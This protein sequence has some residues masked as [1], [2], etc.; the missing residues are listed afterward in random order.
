MGNRVAGIVYVKVD[1][2]QLRTKGAVEVPLSSKKRETILAV[3]GPAGY[4]EEAIAPYV[5]ATVIVTP[6]F[7]ISA[8]T[9]GT[10]MTVNVELANGMVY[11]L[12]EAFLTEEPSLKSDTGEAELSFGGMNGEFQ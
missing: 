8:I 5:K 6:D 3:D 9:S 12:S 10:D 7:P 2:Q 11:T 1:G 4:S